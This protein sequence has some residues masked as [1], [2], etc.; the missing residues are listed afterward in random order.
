MTATLQTGAAFNGQAAVNDFFTRD[1]PEPYRILGLTLL[2]LSIGRYRRMARF[3]CAFVSENEAKTSGSDLILGVLICSMTCAEWD[4]LSIS[5]KLQKTISRWLR[6][7]KAVP[8]FYLRGKWGRV[9]SAT[10]VGRLWRKYNSFDLLEKSKLFNEYIA[11][12]QK[13][14]RFLTKESGHGVSNSHWSHNIEV[15]LMGELGWT[16]K[17]IEERPLSKAL[18][19]Y[20]KHLEN[21]GLITIL[22][23]LD[24]QMI[25][26]NNA[27]I[28]QSLK[29]E[30]TSVG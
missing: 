26:S 23:E 10:W 27:A 20:F 28:E 18:A 2:P 12:A 16:H 21:Q 9:I 22:T 3:G 19:D 6:T 17:D 25:Q 5:G 24:W 29:K 15:V 30:A 14:P 7:I 8:P 13:V 4:A 1:I 11:D